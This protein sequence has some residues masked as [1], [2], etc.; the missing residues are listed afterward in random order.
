[1]AGFRQG[2]IDKIPPAPSLRKG[3]K[4]EG[5]IEKVPLCK[6][7]FRGIFSCQAHFLL[8]TSKFPAL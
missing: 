4:K 5:I 1:M 6:V 3:R 2:K 7:G 8:L